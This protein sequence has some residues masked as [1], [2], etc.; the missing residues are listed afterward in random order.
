MGEIT[1][2]KKQGSDILDHLGVFCQG[3]RKIIL[4]RFIGK[5]V[6]IGVIIINI[7]PGGTTF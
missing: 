2:I 4:T 1:K 5:T 3:A 6:Y 7:F